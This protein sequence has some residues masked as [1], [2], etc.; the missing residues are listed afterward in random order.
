MSHVFSPLLIREVGKP[1]RQFS[2]VIPMIFGQLC[3]Y[4]NGWVL[5]IACITWP[6]GILNAG[7]LFPPYHRQ[8]SSGAFL[9]HK[10]N[11]EFVAVEGFV[12]ARA[13]LGKLTESWQGSGGAN[14][15]NISK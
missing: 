8:K 14:G 13:S 7:D 11:I 12:Y 6:G 10:E 3:G 4:L 9:I 5:Q 1:V 2:L 15:I